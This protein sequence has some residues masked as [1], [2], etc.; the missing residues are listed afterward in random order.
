MSEGGAQKCVRIELIDKSEERENEDE[1]AYSD[2]RK[3]LFDFDIHQVVRDLINNVVHKVN[4]IYGL[5]EIEDMNIR[6]MFGQINQYQLTQSESTEC[7]QIRLVN[8]RRLIEGCKYLTTV[9]KQTANFNQG[10]TR[11]TPIPDGVV[12]FF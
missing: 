4:L 6:Q 1:F 3:A 7:Y 11:N 12:S 2:K 10:V 5:I 8:F 9:K